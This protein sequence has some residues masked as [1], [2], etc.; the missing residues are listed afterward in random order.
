MTSVAGL[1][2]QID[3]HSKVIDIHTPPHGSKYINHQVKGEKQR[4]QGGRG[5]EGEGRGGREKCGRGGRERGKGEKG[6]G[7]AHLPRDLS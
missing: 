3:T 7:L 4:G 1:E 2:R 6:R 5:R